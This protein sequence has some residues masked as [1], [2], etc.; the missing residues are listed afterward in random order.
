MAL[1]RLPGGLIRLLYPYFLLKDTFPTACAL[2]K[3]D[4]KGAA[5]DRGAKTARLAFKTQT[6]RS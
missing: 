3:T 4:K 1:P 6:A 2:G 5:T